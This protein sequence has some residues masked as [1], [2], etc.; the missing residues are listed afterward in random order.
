MGTNGGKED[1]EKI[2]CTYL[3]LCEGRDEKEF[4]IAYLN[5]YLIPLN[6]MFEDIQ[7]IDFKGINQ[8][9]KKL[10]ALKATE[11]FD[12]VKGIAVIR[13]AETD[14][15]GA[16]QSIISSLRSCGISSSLFSSNPYYLF[17][18][19]DIDGH[20]QNGTLEDLCIDIV[21][22]DIDNEVSASHLLPCCNDFLETIKAVRGSEFPRRHKNLLH[23]YFSATNKFVDLKIGEAAKA[24]AFNWENQKLNGLKEFLLT[25]VEMVREN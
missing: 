18:Y 6:Q 16:Q 20:W 15:A 1:N 25:I 5:N 22:D 13:D 14:A 21:A 23:T 19:K 10:R 12:T 17:P 9:T 24:G 3:L 2:K 4:L 11:N 7:I 8:L